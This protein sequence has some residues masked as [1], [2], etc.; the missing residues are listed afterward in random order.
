MELR[1]VRSLLL[2]N[3]EEDYFMYKNPCC[4]IEGNLETHPTNRPELIVKICKVCNAKHYE[5]EA[6]PGMFELKEANG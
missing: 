2:H 4:N 1:V 6:E 3:T 5:L